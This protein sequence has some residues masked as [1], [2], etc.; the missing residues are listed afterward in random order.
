[1]KPPAVVPGANEPL[2]P[3]VEADLAAAHA[4]DAAHRER[5]PALY[6][7][8]FLA[9]AVFFLAL[10]L[11]AGTLTLYAWLNI[12]GGFDL[13]LPQMVGITGATLGMLYL[14]RKVT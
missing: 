10:T 7:V 13:T 12:V 2:P 9:A 11:A 4:R 8:G 5:H 14:A 3:E 1:M 6:W